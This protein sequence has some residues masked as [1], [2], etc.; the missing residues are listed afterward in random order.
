MRVVSCVPSL[1]ELA[2]ELL[3]GCLVGR[4]RYCIAPA[5]VKKVQK[6]GG[7]KDLDTDSIIALQP[8]LVLA[9]KE[10][11]EKEQIEMLKAA[12]I[13]VEVFDIRNLSQAIEMVK[14]LGQFLGN[15][16]KAR[17]IAQGME[18]VK[19]APPIKRSSVLYLIWQKPWMCAGGDTFIGDLLDNLGFLNL[20]PAGKRYPVLEDLTAIKNLKPDFI[21]LSSE[22]FPFREKHRDFFANNFPDSIVQLVDGSL[23][24]WYGS[25]TALLPAYLNRLILKPG[26]SN[27]EADPFF[28]AASAE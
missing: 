18:L 4:T 26:G 25:R 9:V 16:L 23:F 10:E 1:S 17:D 22:P 24:S 14:S 3:P 11:N 27:N 13:R 7:T 21:F 28:F 2:E 20:A 6:V 8:D 12:G 5:S 19:T 15:P